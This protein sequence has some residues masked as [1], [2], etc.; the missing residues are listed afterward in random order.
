[1]FVFIIPF[2]SQYTTDNWSQACAFLQRTLTSICNQTDQDF[3]VLVVCSEI[4][5][6]V[7]KNPKIDFIRSTLPIPNSFQEKCKDSKIKTRIGIFYAQYLN[8]SFVMSVD[9]DDLVSNRLVE[10][11]KKNFKGQ[12]LFFDKG[13]LYVE[14]E[15]KVFLKRKDFY[16]WCGTCNIFRFGIFDIPE[17]T[18][19]NYFS[20][21]VMA[22][23]YCLH[24][25]TAPKLLMEKGMS[26]EPLPFPGAIYS[27]DNGINV[28]SA[29]K[30]KLAV[31]NPLRLIKRVLVNYRFLTH[32]IR[33]EFGIWN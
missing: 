32:S 31:N 20:E 23:T 30:K 18:E 10:Y 12:G 26:M 24:H 22:N 29:S 19:F 1:M 4:P 6:G 2:R 33:D 13:Y 25:S 9:A 15:N 21:E 5:D 7:I 27:I 11:T 8:P 3:K 16:K 14:G 17:S 28:S